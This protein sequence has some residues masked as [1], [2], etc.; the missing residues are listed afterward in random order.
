MNTTRITVRNVDQDVIDRV[1]LH[2]RR[3][4][5]S[6]GGIVTAALADHLNWVDYLTGKHPGEA[7]LDLELPAHLEQLQRGQETKP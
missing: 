2:I 4:G 7:G 3:Y 5:L 6:L 1:R